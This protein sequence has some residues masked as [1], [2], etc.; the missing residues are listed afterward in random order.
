MAKDFILASTKRRDLLN[1][2]TP[3]AGWVYFDLIQPSGYL[4][5]LQVFVALA[6]PASSSTCDQIVAA[7][8]GRFDLDSTTRRPM[9]SGQFSLGRTDAARPGVVTFVLEEELT[10]ERNNVDDSTKKPLPI[11]PRKG[12]VATSFAS[13]PRVC[14]S[15]LA[16]KDGRYHEAQLGEF[17]GD[18]EDGDTEKESVRQTEH[19][20]NG[21]KKTS[22]SLW[23]QHRGDIL[24]S[25][26]FC[27]AT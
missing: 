12:L 24:F 16:G 17:D 21:M 20:L 23:V 19:L 9:P 27:V 25:R 7:V 4:L 15:L 18:E 8:L 5:H 11:L 6:P 2:R 3:R 10:R 13:H 14:I 26:A 1:R 22:A